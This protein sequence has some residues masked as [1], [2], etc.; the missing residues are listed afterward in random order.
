MQNRENMQT[1][2]TQGLFWPLRASRGLQTRCFVYP[3]VWSLFVNRGEGCQ[4]TCDQTA[5]RGAALPDCHFSSVS[6]GIGGHAGSAEPCRR[7]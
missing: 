3:Y 1:T 4:A 5:L 6:M 7:A 2:N